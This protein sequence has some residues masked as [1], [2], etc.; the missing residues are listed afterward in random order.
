MPVIGH[1]S[2]SKSL[3]FLAYVF[4]ME[5]FKNYIKILTFSGVYPRQI[6]QIKMWN[7]VVFLSNKVQTLN[8]LLLGGLILDRFAA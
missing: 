6:V 2:P 1:I 4:G 7:R 8:I 5:L 3:S